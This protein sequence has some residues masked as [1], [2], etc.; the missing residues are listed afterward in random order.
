[1]RRLPVRCSHA[2][3]SKRLLRAELVAARSRRDAAALAAAGAALA[4]AGSAAWRDRGCVAAYA[5][6]GDEPPT[7]ALLDALLAAGVV[8]L[9]PVI[10]GADLRWAP[11]TGWDALVSGPLGIPQP[12]ADTAPSPG[13]CDAAVVVVPALA[14]DR[15]GHRLGKGGGYYDRALA[16]VDPDTVVAVVFDDEIFDDVPAEPHDRT[17]GAALT[18]GGWHRLR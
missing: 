15:H 2:V 9:L 14:V 5:S 18:P 4:D 10:A 17:V 1:M 11:Y 8:V 13:L 7:R 16:S 3:E 12:Q 6:V